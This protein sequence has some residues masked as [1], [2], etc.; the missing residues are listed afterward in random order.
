M[1]L[2]VPGPVFT[3]ACGPA[4]GPVHIGAPQ[5]PGSEEEE[6]NNEEGG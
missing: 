1:L 6:D 4:T 3:H 5:L 2:P